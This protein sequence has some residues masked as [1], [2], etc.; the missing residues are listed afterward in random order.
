MKRRKLIV[1]IAGAAIGL[2]LTVVVLIAL[3]RVVDRSGAKPEEVFIRH[4]TD[5]GDAY[6]RIA[7]GAANAWLLPCDGG[8]F[9][10]DTGYPEDYERFHAGLRAA[11]I[12]PGSI[13]WLFLTHSHDEHAGFA[14]RLKRETGLRII[15]PRESLDGL[16]AGRF[17]WN[18]V[19]VNA[20]VDALSRLYN[21]IKRRRFSFEPVFPQNDD[22]VLDSVHSD[23]PRSLGLPARFIHTPGHSA[24]SWSLV[25]DDGRAF[26][27][28]AAMNTLAPLSPGRRPLFMEDREETYRSLAVLVSAGARTF[29]TGHGPAFG[30][31]ELPIYRG[32]ADRGPGFAGL[33]RYALLLAPGFVLVFLLLLATRRGPRSFRLWI[34]ILGFILVRDLMTPLGLWSVGGDPVFWLR[35]AADGPLLLFLAAGSLLLGC[36][37][38]VF[39]R[40]RGPALPWFSR[41]RAKSVAAGLVGGILAAGPLLAFSIGILPGERGG[42]FPLVLLPALIAVAFAG[43]FLEEILFRGYL[44]GEL[45]AQGM[46]APMAG[47]ASGLAFAFCHVFLAY[48]VTTVGIGLLLF[49]AWEGVICGLLRSRYGLVSAVIAHSL[50]VVLVSFF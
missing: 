8:Y 7:A 25:M 4:I 11:G 31:G 41:G 46:K 24:D 2:A 40:G 18:G 21:L 23:L 37:V 14:A 48:T 32:A 10:V 19:S 27:G 12:D 33:G 45:E 47:I 15:M 34:L 16:A 3:V 6:W 1:L 39:E 50:A 44:Q 26:V 43:N 42:A 5:S 13:R 35:F 38:L 17:V 22:I 36:G 20:A 30:A 29:L 9:L 28:D 49:A